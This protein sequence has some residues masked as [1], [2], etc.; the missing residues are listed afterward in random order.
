MIPPAAKKT[1]QTIVCVVGTRPEAI[2]M[3][4]VILSL[5]NTPEFSIY[6]LATGQHSDMLDQAL[7]HFRIEPEYNLRIMREKQSLDYVTARVLEGSGKVFDHVEPSMVLVHG[8]TTTTLAASLAAFYRHIPIGHVEA[9]LRSGRLDLPFPEEANRILTDKIS[10]LLFA[11]TGNAR[12]NLIREGIPEDNITV[13][14][15]TVIDALSWT[16]DTYGDSVCRSDV[17]FPGDTRFIVFTAHRRESWG[18]PLVEICTA[19]RRLLELHTDLFVL[20]PLHKNPSVR[21]KIRHE[22]GEHPRI[23]YSEP[24]DYASFVSAMRHCAFLLSDSGGIQEEAAALG[25]PVLVLRDVSERP[26]AMTEGTAVLVGTSA[27]VIVE[28]AERILSALHGE[29]NVPHS[30]LS[31]PFG[32]GRAAW[33]ISEGISKYFNDRS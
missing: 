13:T 16:I 8:D 33:R 27:D 25:K 14:G 28:N 22:L 12:D 29:R 30:I 6:T 1:P 2:K 17:S 20:I 19:V 18:E 3:A 32:D 10:R 23:V 11:P 21:D 24:L 26:E 31:N 9:G 7:A 5:R 4:P 15:N